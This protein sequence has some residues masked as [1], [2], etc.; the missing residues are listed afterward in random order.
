[1]YA[2]NRKY[3]LKLVE[4]EALNVLTVDD[5]DIFSGKSGR[6]AYDGGTVLFVVGETV[7]G[8]GGSAGVIAAVIGDIT[9]GV[10]VLNECTG[11]FVNNEVLSG[12][13]AGA[14]VANGILGPHTGNWTGFTVIA[15][16]VFNAITTGGGVK[17][18]VGTHTFSANFSCV[19][20]IR[21]IELVSGVIMAHKI[22]EG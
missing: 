19:K 18:N 22:Y 12:S 8:A 15:A 20:D 2:D 7:T 3:L 5:F 17:S 11:A 1:M 13:V 16:T 9:S 6:L 14:A 21:A 10:L 4:Q